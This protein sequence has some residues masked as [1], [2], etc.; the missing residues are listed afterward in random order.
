MAD[1][2]FEA[3]LAAS[4]LIKPA[5][6]IGLGAGSTIAHL[7][8]LLAADAS[9]AASL[10]L[11]SSS[12]KTTRLM[13]DRGLNVHAIALTKTLDIYFDGCD[14]FDT[15]L[16]ALKSGGGIHTSEKIL[17]S[18]ADEFILTGDAAKFAPRLDTTY[19]LVIEVLPST[20]LSDARVRRLLPWRRRQHPDERQKGR[21]GN[22]R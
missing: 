10:T 7:V 19:P 13:M 22:Y 5:Q 11:V 18:L 3:A 4:R 2:K 21:R 8:S 16:N 17:A 20:S 9:L 1:Y 6:T 14:Q 12:F 15:E